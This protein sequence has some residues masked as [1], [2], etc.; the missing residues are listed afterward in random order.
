MSL[1]SKEE[2]KAKYLMWSKCEDT[3]ATGGKSYTI[4][5]RTFTRADLPEIR[6][7][8]NY[9]ESKYNALNRKRKAKGFIFRD[10]V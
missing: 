5:G 2:A 8:M 10:D 1:I 3:V 6:K 4:E 7:Q 9:W